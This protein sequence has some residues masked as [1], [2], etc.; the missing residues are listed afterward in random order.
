MKKIIF[1][2]LLSLSQLSFT[3]VSYKLDDY[4]NIVDDSK[5]KG[6]SMKFR[7]P[8][9]WEEVEPKGPNTVKKYIYGTNTIVISIKDSPTFISRSEAKDLLS[10]SEYLKE[11]VNNIS[12]DS[13]VLNYSLVTVGTYP[14]LE[15]LKLTK[16]EKLGINYNIFSLMWLI[17]YEDKLISVS[18][19]SISNDDFKDY[20]FLYYFVADS[21]IFP[22]QYE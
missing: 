20:L 8:K 22:E 12:G 21:I 18:G 3:Q 10:D 2:F 1:F 4:I 17:F 14:T 7:P 11:L 6:V 9:I 5:A 16:V 15:L 19:A 13:E